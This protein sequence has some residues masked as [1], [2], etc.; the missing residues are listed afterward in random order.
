MLDFLWSGAG[1][2][3]HSDLVAQNEPVVEDRRTE[4]EGGAVGEV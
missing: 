4:P 3:A 2:N 1:R